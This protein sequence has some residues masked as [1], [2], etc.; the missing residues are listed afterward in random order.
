M[1]TQA[2]SSTIRKTLNF[3]AGPA[4]LPTSVLRIAETEFLNYN[5]TGV[6]VMELSHRSKDFESIIFTAIK[7]LRELMDIPA[8]YEVLFMHGGGTGQ[9]AAVPMNLLRGE[10]KASYVITGSWSAAAAEEAKK[11]VDDIE[12]AAHTGPSFTSLP[13][14]WKVSADSAYIHYC[15]NETVNG[16]QYHNILE[17]ASKY[18]TIPLVADMS[19]SFLSEPVDVRRFGC[20][21]AGAQKNVGPA[22]VTIVIVRKDLLGNPAKFT[23]TI[24]NYTITAAKESMYN[25]PPTY[26]IYITSL[27][28]KWIKQQSLQHLSNVNKE[29]AQIL[30]DYIDQSN[31][32][33][34]AKI[35]PDA[36]SRMNVVFLL[37]SEELTK[38]F[39]K[40]AEKHH[41]MGIAGHRSVGGCRASIY[42]AVPLEHVRELI[43]FMKEFATAHS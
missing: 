9:F 28:L 34:E 10:K 39:V 27:V 22:G 19:S 4:A 36:R 16:N 33:Y 42:N 14:E 29:K 11:Y 31:G 25:T 8:E 6:S 2:S 17:I 40:E 26:P 23:P 12:I 30:Y 1:T 13:S 24:L 5:K 38:T 20:I 7:D 35:E 41:I 21:Y 18:P 37:K 43:Q 3:N 32:F 15:H